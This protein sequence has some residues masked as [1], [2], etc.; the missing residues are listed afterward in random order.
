V[1]SSTATGTTATASPYR[2]RFA[3]SPTGFLHQGSLL[4]ALGSWLDA[5][6]NRGKWLVRMEDLDRP[7][8]VEGAADAML[9]TLDSLGLVADEPVLWQ[10]LREEAYSA[11]LAQL[12]GSGVL[13]RCTC[14]RAELSGPYSG[15]CLRHPAGRT[16][17]LAPETAG[18]CAD[19]I[20]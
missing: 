1:K 9:R 19:F 8:T 17:S 5:R 14:S 2:G 15:H 7:R 6:A 18:G 12:R 20:R 11:A 3:P 10:T 16:C 13:Y 4:A